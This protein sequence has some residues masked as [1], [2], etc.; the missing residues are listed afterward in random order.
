MIITVIKGDAD[1]DDGVARYDTVCQSFLDPLAHRRDI[2]F[3]YD[4]A[5]D[6]IDELEPATLLGRFNF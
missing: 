4:A 6:L 1:I 5:D 3:R 2:V